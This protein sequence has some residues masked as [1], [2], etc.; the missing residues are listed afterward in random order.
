[1]IPPMM[2]TAIFEKCGLRESGSKLEPMI[3]R[4]QSPMAA[5]II[6]IDLSRCGRW[7]RS[8]SGP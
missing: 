6:R 2:A 5:S 4:V 1:M 7:L 8:V 3:E